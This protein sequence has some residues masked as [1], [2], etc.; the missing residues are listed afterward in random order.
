MVTSVPAPIAN[1]TQLTSPPST[2]SAIRTTSRSGPLLSIE[3]PNSLESWLMRTV[4][5]MPFM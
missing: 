3:K 1:V 4:R 2:A 5:A